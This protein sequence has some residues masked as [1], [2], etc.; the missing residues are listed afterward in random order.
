KK[1]RAAFALLLAATALFGA[2][3]AVARDRAY[4]SNALH[5]LKL[6]EYAD[7]RGKLA[8]SPSREL[9]R[10]VYI[11]KVSRVRSGGAEREV[12]GNLRLTVPRAADSPPRPDLFAG[13]EVAVSARIYASREFDNFNAPFYARFLKSRNIH[14]RAFAKSALLLERTGPAPSWS[15]FRAASVLRRKLQRRL[16]LSFPGPQPAG[17]SPE[18]AVLEAL[19]LGDDGRMDEATVL[20]LQRTGLYHLFAISGAHIAIVSFLFFSLFKLAR[21]PRRLSYGILIAA[22]V[23][24]ALLVEGSPS[25]LRAVIMTVAFLAGKLFW[26]DAHILNAIALS[27]FVLLVANPFSLFDV[28]FQL[29]FAATL[30]IILFQPKLLRLLP[31]LPLG[32]GELAAMS[33]AATAGVLPI[34]VSDFNRV[35]FSSLIL[36]FAAVPLVGLVMGLGYACFPVAFAFPFLAGPMALGLRALV[37]V[38][39]WV[40]GLLDPVPFVSYRVPTP[41]AWV[42]VGY[43]AFLLLLLAPRRFRGQKAAA[44]AAFAVFFVVL[45]SFPFP[46]RSSVFKVTVL[47]V[48]QGDAILVEFPGRRKMLIDAGGFPEGRFD[49]GESVVS[50]FLWRKGIK[51]L[52][53]LVLT[54]PHPDHL[55]GLPAVARNFRIGEFWEAERPA[56]SEAYRALD[57]ALGKRVPRRTV[58]RGFALRE[59]GVVIEVL[60][61]GPDEAPS[62]ASDENDRSLVLRLTCDGASFLFAGDIGREAEAAILRAVPDVRA[63][64]LK[65]PHHG[66]D[67]S[68]SVAFL[69]RVAPE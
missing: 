28:G 8:L 44:L 68:S 29:T 57:A 62:A 22:L 50:P 41:P 45:V 6:D 46:S 51:R 49:V 36:N 48:G 23:F 11:L 67:T 55:G 2:A 33:V 53:R 4:E 52:D 54:H 1:D 15:V 13:D 32:I 47:D 5:A 24:Y 12:R 9:D 42:V 7:F 19:L 10:D 64:V 63:R 37:R 3:L 61:P 58:G 31:K 35:T 17:I 16:E 14:N 65:S 18:G 43:F 66:S 60:N 38:F 40:S 59:S 25:V 56:V 26:K 39:A 30:S 34:L 69:E 21:V 27:A 20:S